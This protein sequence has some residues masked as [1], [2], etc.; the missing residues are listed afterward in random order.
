MSTRGL[1][2]ARRRGGGGRGNQL[3]RGLESQE[4]RKRVGRGIGEGNLGL[5]KNER[6]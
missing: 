5:I 1:E 6:L 2:T 3:L 4:E